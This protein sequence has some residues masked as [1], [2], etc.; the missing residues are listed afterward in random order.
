MAN[1]VTLVFITGFFD[2]HC[3]FAFYVRGTKNTSSFLAGTFGK[4]CW[5]GPSFATPL[6]VYNAREVFTGSGIHANKFEKVTRHDTKGIRW[7]YL[8]ESAVA[9]W[10]ALEFDWGKHRDI[11]ARAAAE[12][13]PTEELE[14]M[15]LS[16]GWKNRAECC[17]EL[18]SASWPSCHRSCVKEIGRKYTEPHGNCLVVVKAPDTKVTRREHCLLVNM[19]RVSRSWSWKNSIESPKKKKNIVSTF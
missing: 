3:D 9:A 19:V 6:I 16:D 17:V 7:K 18:I 1:H 2:D 15:E 10:D 11:E 5:D 13:W 4:K 8:Y 12:G 14:E